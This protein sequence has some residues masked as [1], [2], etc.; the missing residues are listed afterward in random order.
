MVDPEFAPLELPDEEIG[1][2]V[3]VNVSVVRVGVSVLDVYVAIPGAKAD[4]VGEA[5]VAPIGREGEQ[6]KKGQH[7]VPLYDV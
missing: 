1:V 6:R 7:E 2:P 3:S 5:Q 4:G